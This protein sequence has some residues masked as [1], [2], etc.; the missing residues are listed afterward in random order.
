MATATSA[1]LAKGLITHFRDSKYDEIIHTKKHRAFMTRVKMVPFAGEDYQCPVYSSHGGGVSG[2]LSDAQNMSTAPTVGR[3]NVGANLAELHKAF[4]IKSQALAR[5][6]GNK[7][8]GAGLL[9]A[10]IL[11]SESILDHLYD[12]LE[13]QIVGASRYNRIGVIDMASVTS[14]TLELATASDAK[15]FKSGMQIVC[16]ATDGGALRTGTGDGYSTVSTDGDPV[17]GTVELVAAL[18][19]G[20]TDVAT[21]DSIYVKGADVNSVTQIHG[22]AA[23]SS[24]PTGSEDF[25]GQDRTAAAGQLAMLSGTGSVS[26]I[27]SAIVLNDGLAMEI[28]GG[29]RDTALINP[30]DF[31]LFSAQQAALTAQKPASKTRAGY[32]YIAVSGVTGQTI[33]TVASPYVPR[34]KIRLLNMKSWELV[35]LRQKPIMMD[36]LDGNAAMKLATDSGSEFRGLGLCQLGSSAPGTNVDITLS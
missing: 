20:I 10:A 11:T 17:A 18:D 31:G 34:N 8:M 14:T 35:H 26:A 12:D 30:Y 28:N 22:L 1:N 19:T 23:Y 25:L 6:Q 15:Y 21:A 9:K 2:V 3:F 5:A 27:L 16:S 4:R 24:T 36:D 13:R 33:E 32:S 29:E 7:R